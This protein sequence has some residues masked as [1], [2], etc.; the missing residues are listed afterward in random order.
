MVDFMVTSLFECKSTIA[1]PDS[2][3][4]EG[5]SNATNA[6]MAMATIGIPRDR[7]FV[8]VFT[9]TGSLVQV[10]VVYLLEPRLPAVCF[11]TPPLRLSEEEDCLEAA[12]ILVAMS[13]H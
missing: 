9:T 12:K 7:I 8:P 6:A 2:G 3:H 10:A 11:V 13:E 5:I 4:G 1:S